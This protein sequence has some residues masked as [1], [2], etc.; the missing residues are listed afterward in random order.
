MVLF[1]KMRSLFFIKFIKFCAVGISGVAVDMGVTYIC[2][3]MLRINKYIASSTGFVCAASSNYFL[4][5]IWTFRSTDPNVMR[6]YLFFFGIALVGLM[7][8][9]FILW[10]LNDKVAVDFCR[11]FRKHLQQP[12]PDRL[13][14]YCAKL[15]AILIVTVWNFMANAILTF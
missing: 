5:R 6:Q 11:M 12:N 13:N 9:N 15:V 7:F 4:N 8:N 14:F 1:K 10:L 3:E 2:K